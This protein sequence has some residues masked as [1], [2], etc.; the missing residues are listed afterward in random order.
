MDPEN[1]Q[2]T[3]ENYHSVTPP[4]YMPPIEAT[5]NITPTP[6]QQPIDNSADTVAPTTTT[7]P[8]SLSL[9]SDVPPWAWAATA[10]IIVGILGVVGWRIYS[11]NEANRMIA[12]SNSGYTQPKP[13]VFTQPKKA[14]QEAP[15]NN[16]VLPTAVNPT[17]A[18]TTTVTI[19]DQ[20]WMK[21]NMNAG[22]SGVPKA[23]LND[24]IVEK[25]CYNL[26]EVNCDIYGGLYTWD[27]AMQY[28]T[29]ERA[30]G[31]CPA[32]FHI[33]SKDDFSVLIN[34]F[35]GDRNTNANSMLIFGG[36]GEFD[37]RLG[38]AYFIGVNSSYYAD[39]GGATYFW[40]ST[41]DNTNSNAY[42]LGL[43]SGKGDY[44]GGTNLSP[45]PKGYNASVRCVKDLPAY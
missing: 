22:T 21:Y 39:F 30:Q 37:G 13:A 42:T 8:T 15:A 26:D 14:T 12:E 35:G 16:S 18:S 38:G 24:N 45:L 19:S 17:I 27:E 3:D 33:P 5:P 23:L 9:K 31:I 32:G 25:D 7:T 10:V 29:T 34:N 44:I 28:S 2:K 6:Q 20:V 11:V 4:P 43:Y 41:L 1:T 40:T 36:S